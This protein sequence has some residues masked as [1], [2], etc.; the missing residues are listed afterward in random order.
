[1][2]SATDMLKRPAVIGILALIVG[3]IIGLGYA[4]GIDP[5]QW[6]DQPMN[7]TRPDLQEQYLRM[8]IDSFRVN[9]EQGL[10]VQRYNDLQPNSYQIF[11]SIKNNPETIDP[12]V[13][14]IFEQ[15]L[16]QAGVYQPGGSTASGTPAPGGRAAGGGNPIITGAIIAGG[17]LAIVLVAL[18]V[19]Y[20][21][22]S[23][24]SG[25]AMTPAQHAAE[26]NRSTEK[27]DYAA[28]GEE[29]PVAQYV[30][31]YV[32]GDDLFDDSFSIDSPSGEFLGEC[33][34]GISETIGVG[35][36]KKVAAFEV[37]MFD[38]NDIQTI[39][40]VLMS[41]HAFN[42]PGFHQK[43]EAKGELIQVEPHQQIVLETQTLQM[44][45]TISD[46]QYGQGALPENSYFE[47]MTLE[48]AIWPKQK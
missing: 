48:L 41:P 27:T 37:W 12:Q 6:T 11:Q 7:N 10:A 18:A 2:N 15:V 22:R 8:A 45:A 24:R 30:T 42:D 35:D 32:L 46:L 39:T 47:R 40:K 44:M 23:S 31:T 13:I 29:S 33:G 5:V 1:M 28:K 36:P 4:W 14:A 43:L 21:F 25:G 3:I 19:F 26:L 9:G 34:V 16:T 38:K 17:L 20:L